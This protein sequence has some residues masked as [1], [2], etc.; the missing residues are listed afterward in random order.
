MPDINLWMGDT[1]PLGTWTDD[2]DKAHDIAR[3]IAEKITS[4]TVIRGGVAQAAQNVRIETME[5]GE[6][7]VTVNGRQHQVDAIV[8]GYASHPTITATDLQPGDRFVANGERYE[9]M[10]LLVGLSDMLQAFCEVL[11]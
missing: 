10:V 8:Y 4:I 11:T 3:V 6:R 5:R 1:F 2:V 9:V 7:T